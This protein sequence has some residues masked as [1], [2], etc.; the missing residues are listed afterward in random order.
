MNIMTGKT[1]LNNKIYILNFFTIV[2]FFLGFFLNEDSSGSGKFDFFNFLLLSQSAISNDIVGTIL[3]QNLS[4]YTP[5]HFIIYIPIY[6]LFGA[7]GL[8]VTNFILSFLVIY[9]FYLTLQKRFMNIEKKYLLSVSFLPLLDPYFRSAAY[10]FQNDITALIFFSLS[11]Y[12]FND[13]SLKIKDQLTISKNE[14]FKK[15]SLIFIFSALAFYCKQNYIFFTIFVFFFNFIKIRASLYYIYSCILNLLLY[16]PFFIYIYFFKN[17]T[18]GAGSESLIIFSLQNTLIFFSFV[19]FYF[20]PLI[21]FQFNTKL[22]MLKKNLNLFITSILLF[23]I[24]LFFFNYSSTLG[25]GVY[26]KISKVLFDNYLIFYLMSY[27]GLVMFLVVV[28]I[29]ILNNLLIFIPLFLFINLV[30]IP[31]Q[32]YFAIFFFYIFFIIMNKNMVSN[33]FINFK[34]KYLFLYSYFFLFLLGSI[35]YNFYNLKEFI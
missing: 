10:W 32:E 16:L 24:M 9:I 31:F 27:I 19:S 2:I 33:I 14:I 25:G 1:I 28:R 13:F 34:K 11:L 8:R 5:L 29:D 17:L 18:P 4:G 15:T 20:F 23:V 21:V 22:I 35:L 3:N 30:R 7:Q 26:Y 6:D 12:F